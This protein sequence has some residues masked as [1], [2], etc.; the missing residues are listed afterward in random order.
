MRWL[1]SMPAT[2]ARGLTC[3]SIPMPQEGLNPLLAVVPLLHA[4]LELPSLANLAE[5]EPGIRVQARA[6]VDTIT[7]FVK[8][9]GMLSGAHFCTT[10]PW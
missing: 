1:A 3:L 8:D 4:K 2:N 6:D 5:T 9:L 7:M 10:Y